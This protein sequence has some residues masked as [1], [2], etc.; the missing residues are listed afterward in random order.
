MPRNYHIHLRGTVGY[1]N[2]SSEQVA[3]ILDKHKDE[4]YMCSSTRSAALRMTA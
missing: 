1:W 2:F 4:E 3:Y